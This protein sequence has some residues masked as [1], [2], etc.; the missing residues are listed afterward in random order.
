MPKPKEP[1]P[2]YQGRIIRVAAET[3]TLPNGEVTRLDVVRHP[4]A[5]AVVPV[6]D[7]GT[8]LLIHQ[9]RHA[10]GGYLY[11]VPAGTLAEG[12]SPDA[13]AMREVEEETG[14]RAGR[15]V[16]LGSIV[17]APG[18]CDEQIHLYL[19][20]RLEQSRQSLDHDEV[21]TVVEMSLD[22]AM[23][24]VHD[25]TIRDAKSIAALVLASERIKG[26]PVISDK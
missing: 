19:A 10:A 17:T 26:Q 8:V 12:E 14:Y 4:G 5:S 13:C 7:D 11:E 20:T 24:K 3:V 2:P 18:F 1:P 9:F 6:K 15:L 23:A 21:L 16:R 25:N 22:E